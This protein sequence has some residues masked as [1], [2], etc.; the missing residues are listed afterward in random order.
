MWDCYS[1]YKNWARVIES[2]CDLTL[3]LF[4]S[5]QYC[6]AV[7]PKIMLPWN[8]SPAHPAKVV[9]ENSWPLK[10]GK[11]YILCLSLEGSQCS[12]AYQSRKI[13]P[14]NPAVKTYVT[15]PNSCM[16]HLDSIPSKYLRKHIL[17]SPSGRHA[18]QLCSVRWEIFTG[19]FWDDSCGIKFIRSGSLPISFYFLSPT[20]GKQNLPSLKTD[21]VCSEICWPHS[22]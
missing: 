12:L 22:V 6:K 11:G 17:L 13:S 19:G 15:L 5:K 14:R 1:Q 2:E 18:A 16:T 7:F 3:L 4:S 8:T 20:Q 9:C 10:W 21:R